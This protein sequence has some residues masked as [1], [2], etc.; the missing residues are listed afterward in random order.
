MVGDH[1]SGRWHGKDGRA[2]RMGSE[3]EVAW[4]EERTP[5][6]LAITSAIPPAGV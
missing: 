6:G 5:G 2:W 4:I 3:A 1:S